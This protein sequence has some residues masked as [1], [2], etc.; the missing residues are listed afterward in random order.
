MIGAGEGGAGRSRRDPQ[1]K[2]K[3][4]SGTICQDASFSTACSRSCHERPPEGRA[5]VSEKTLQQTP[6]QLIMNISSVIAM[7]RMEINKI[8][9]R[10]F[11]LSNS[12]LLRN[13]DSFHKGTFWL[14]S[15]TFPDNKKYG[16]EVSFVRFCKDG[17]TTQPVT[18]CSNYEME[19]P[20][21]ADTKPPR[22]C[23]ISLG[24]YFFDAQS[25]NPD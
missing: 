21:G 25:I 14:T 6:L 8:T 18:S 16:W 19:F 3:I 22:D 2:S 5:E 9:V 12:S 4:L 23:P 13:K 1:D 15:T 10:F 11:L 17:L 24:A 7:F 20:K